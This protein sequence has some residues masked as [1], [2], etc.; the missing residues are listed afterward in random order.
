VAGFADCD[1][2]RDFQKEF[3]H[4]GY[5]KSLKQLVHFYN[6]RDGYPFA[7]ESGHCSSGTTERVNCWPAAEV[8][9]NQDMT[10]GKLNL[11][12][13]EE[14]Q[15]VKFLETLTDGFTAAGAPLTPT[16]TRIPALA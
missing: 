6:T 9:Q 3:F 1:C 16:S 10:V 15:I 7:V 5:I 12:D 11:T 8:P 2:R 13:V 4:N 14:N